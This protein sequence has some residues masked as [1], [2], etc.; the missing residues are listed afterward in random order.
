MLYPLGASREHT[1]RAWS[2]R[3]VFV[4]FLQT[5]VSWPQNSPSS[6]DV[7]NSHRLT[8]SSSSA[9]ASHEVRV[10]ANA[11]LVG[12]PEHDSPDSCG[13]VSFTSVASIL[14]GVSGVLGGVNQAELGGELSSL[15]LRNLPE[16]LDNDHSIWV[17]VT[18]VLIVVKPTSS[19]DW[20]VRASCSGAGYL[21]V[22][23]LFTSE[24]SN[25]CDRSRYDRLGICGEYRPVA[26]M[27]K[28]GIQ[29]SLSCPALT[30]PY[31][32]GCDTERC[33]G[34]VEVTRNVFGE[35]VRLP[36]STGSCG[37][38][39]RGGGRWAD[40][41]ARGGALNSIPPSMEVLLVSCWLFIISSSSSVGVTASGIVTSSQSASMLFKRALLVLFFPAFPRGKAQAFCRATSALTLTDPLK[42]HSCV[43]GWPLRLSKQMSSEDSKMSVPRLLHS[44]S[45]SILSDFVTRNLL[46][47]PP[48][49]ATMIAS[50]DSPFSSELQTRH[51]KKINTPCCDNGMV[52]L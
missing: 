52:L 14:L 13:G 24:L 32:G 16:S 31:S 30:L 25:H 43:R 3:N 40:G 29:I 51:V 10:M 35:G 5:N 23:L 41:E 9:D 15:L 26:C 11:V 28:T 47:L 22:E 37:M 44:W 36:E 34:L 27:S 38:T 39:R 42:S 45:P 20:E 21:A 48:S 33:R 17:G 1:S 6:S 49:L 46:R 19:D 7:K 4:F 8:H 18:V 50:D 2:E 12:L